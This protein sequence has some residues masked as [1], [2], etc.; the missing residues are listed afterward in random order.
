MWRNETIFSI[1]DLID[2]EQWAKFMTDTYYIY[3]EEVVNE[4]IRDRKDHIKSCI[5]RL[6][7]ELSEIDRLAK[8][9][10]FERE[11]IIDDRAVRDRDR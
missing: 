5:D 3:D 2:G 4:A 1:G 11:K 6:L 7:N 9:L 8:L 10:P